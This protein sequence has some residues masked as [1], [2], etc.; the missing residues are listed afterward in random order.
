MGWRRSIR[1]ISRPPDARQPNSTRTAFVWSQLPKALD[2][3]QKTYA[4]ADECGLV[5]LGFIAFLDPPKESAG[6]ALSALSKSGVRVMILTGDN[7]IVTRKVC[8][9]DVGL[10][11][12]EIAL[13]RDIESRRRGAG[14][15]GRTRNVFAK[16]APAQKKALSPLCIGA[17]M[18]SR[19][20]R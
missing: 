10:D 8:C 12:G 5:L 19:L 14:W 16:L 1:N 4:P 13:G 20:S 17:V 3:A 11:P 18:S 9:R 6:V 7:D 15:V 2:I